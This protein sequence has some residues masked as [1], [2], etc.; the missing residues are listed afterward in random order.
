M[1]YTQTNSRIGLN[2][3]LEARV[4]TEREEVISLSFDLSKSPIDCPLKMN[5]IQKLRQ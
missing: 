5:L 4:I 2:V 1:C 3:I